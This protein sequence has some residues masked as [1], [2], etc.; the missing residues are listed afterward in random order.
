MENTTTS[1]LGKGLLIAAVL[2]L[3]ALAFWLFTLWRWGR[4]VL[5]TIDYSSQNLA[6]RSGISIFLVKGLIILVT[7]PFF[8]AV[9]RYMHGFWF[10]FRGVGPGLRLYRSAP[11]MIIVAYVGIFYLAMYYASREALAY[12]WCADTPEGLRAFDS[13]GID[14][15]YGI[16]LKPCTFDQKIALREAKIG[17]LG[18]RKLD[19]GDARQ[20][21]FFSTT[22]KPRVWYSKRPDGTFEFYD[23]QGPSPETGEELRPV[24]RK[25]REEIIR[26]QKAAADQHAKQQAIEAATE[27]EFTKNALI[28]RY[29]N[30]AVVKR[31]GEKQ[32]AFLV[33]AK[34]P[35]SVSGAEESLGNALATQGFR[36]VATFFK[37]AFVQDGRAERLMSGDWKQ[38]TELEIKKRVDYVVLA[39]ASV[40]FSSSSQFEGIISAN[41]TLQ[42]KCLNMISSTFCG[43]QSFETVGAG[44]TNAAALENA[45]LKA[46]PQ[47]E[48]FVRTL[49]LN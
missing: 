19:I 43:S 7:I 47:M 25:T 10:W 14:P 5:S 9:A 28:E 4:F 32:V 27:Q 45:T 26:A 6:A 40:G 24:D 37:P 44:Y 41:L 46:R 48:S 30:T 20:F 22:D 8:W 21:A 35:D 3:A 23:R 36:P 42:L 49:R 34:G 29:I 15:I 31:V 12:K 18:P 16:P 11:G 33:L 13:G 38:A 2:P 17:S 1:R 39:R